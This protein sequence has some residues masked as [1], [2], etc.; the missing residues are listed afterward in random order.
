VQTVAENIEFVRDLLWQE[1]AM[2]DRG[3]RMLVIGAGVNGSVVAVEL[4][5]AGYDV[6]VLA[7]GKRFEELVVRGIDRI[8]F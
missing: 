4:H 1:I 8:G 5:R 6:T 7:R 2:N 3:L